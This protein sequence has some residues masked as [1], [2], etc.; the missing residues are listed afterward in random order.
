MMTPSTILTSTIIEVLR[1]CAGHD[2]HL[3]R[4]SR[5]LPLLSGRHKP[6]PAGGSNP[7][8]PRIIHLSLGIHAHGVKPIWMAARVNNLCLRRS[9]PGGVMAKTVWRHLSRKVEPYTASMTPRQRQPVHY[10]HYQAP[11]PHMQT[12]PEP[13]PRRRRKRDAFRPEYL[14]VPLVLLVVMWVLSGVDGAAFSFEEV[15]DGL[16][17]Q[18]RN[19]YRHLAT[20]GLIVVAAVW[21]VKI[22]KSPGK[23]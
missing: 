6:I 23:Q 5:S 9:P 20:L 10:G 3:F 8:H 19:Q 1:D 4:C 13:P 16:N 15:M 18:Q 21:I 7:V 11:Q 2:G 14:L 22:L 12:P 17:V